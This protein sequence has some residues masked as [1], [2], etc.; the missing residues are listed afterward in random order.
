MAIRAVPKVETNE[1]SEARQKLADAISAYNELQSEITAIRQAISETEQTRRHAREIVEV[2]NEQM[3]KAR[4]AN[5]DAMVAK[6]LGR[7]SGNS[8]D[9]KTLRNVIDVA[10]DEIDAAEAALTHLRTKLEQAGRDIITRKAVV[11]DLVPAVIRSSPELERLFHDYRTAAQAFVD[12]RNVFANGGLPWG[13]TLPE[14]EEFKSR[15]VLPAPSR[16]LAASWKS[17]IEA[18]RKDADAELP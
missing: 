2:S 12:I 5:A 1:R 7:S 18:L 17:A 8:I 11:E 10:Q 3:E 4:T 13:T 6:A 15:L 14:D 16:E 9:L